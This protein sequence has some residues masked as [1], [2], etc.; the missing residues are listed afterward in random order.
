MK[1]RIHHFFDMVRDFGSG[2]TFLPHPY[3]HAY[4][5]VAKEIWSNPHVHL[6]LVVASDAVCFGCL[7]QKNSSC[8]DIITHRKDFTSKEAFNNYLDKRI[9]KVCGIQNSDAYTP[10]ELCRFAGK[11]L[12]N[13][14]FIYEGND[15]EHTRERKKN[16]MKGLSLYAQK[17]RLTSYDG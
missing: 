8:D 16:V 12:E 1:I 6:N 7:H 17:H 9:M 10:E 2:K 4:H 5:L 14:F 15:E 13:I 3:Q 11:Y